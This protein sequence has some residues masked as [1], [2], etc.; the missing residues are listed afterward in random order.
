V[1]DV[2]PSGEWTSK[3]LPLKELA[4][5]S[6]RVLEIRLLK[7]TGFR[8]EDTGTER[9]PSKAKFTTVEGCTGTWT[10]QAQG[11]DHKSTFLF[12]M[13]WGPALFT[14]IGEI[15]EPNLLAIG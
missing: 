5:M 9:W 1:R 6:L 13:Q 10:Q 3:H 12:L 2:S 4:Q 14:W 15:Q 11:I 7:T 8:I